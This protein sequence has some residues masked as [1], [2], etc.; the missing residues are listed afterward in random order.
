MGLTYLALLEV[1][2][3]RCRHTASPES[4]LQLCDNKAMIRPMSVQFSTIYGGLLSLSEPEQ[5]LLPW[6]ALDHHSHFPTTFTR[7]R[8]E[9]CVVMH[10]LSIW[11]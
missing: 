3:S 10:T 1:H 8:G 7:V 6:L 9:R 5:L 4:W 11:P 2:L